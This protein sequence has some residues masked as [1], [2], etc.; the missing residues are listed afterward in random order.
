M[1]IFRAV[2][3]VGLALLL[4]GC[5]AQSHVR[6]NSVSG[7]KTYV[8]V[9]GAWGGGWAFRQVDDL[10]TA[11]G[12]KVYRPTLT[13]QG[14]RVHLAG[15][16][17]GLDTHIQDVVNTILFEELHDVVLVGHSY[18]GMVATG[19]ADRI[20]E[21]IGH[22]IYLDAIVPE[23]GESVITGWSRDDK[24]QDWLKNAE[25]GFLKPD[26]VKSDQPVPKD[27]PHP[28]KTFTDTIV[29][30]NQDRLRIPTSYILTVDPGT[31]ARKDSFFPFAERAGKLGWPVYQMQSDHNPQWSAPQKLVEMLNKA[32][33]L[34]PSTGLKR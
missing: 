33:K 5:G 22:L 3:V 11:Q 19:V 20:C 16:D 2:T 23:D 7:P 4:S 24:K 27:V 13:G 28:I 10:L 30:K 29:L 14:E 15:L 1:Y 12:H 21:R 26:W 6:Q 18:G 34:H 32:V 25:D 31:E 9:H 8:I 17:M